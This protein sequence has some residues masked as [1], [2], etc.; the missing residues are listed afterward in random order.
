MS[1]LAAIVSSASAGATHHALR[2]GTMLSAMRT[3][4]DEIIE[5]HETSAAGVLLAMATGTHA[6]ERD[7][8]GSATSI[9]ARGPLACASDARLY[10]RDDLRRAL[11][12]STFPLSTDAELILA[13]YEKWD[14]DGFTRLEGDFAFVLWDEARGRLVAARDFAGH[15]MLYHAHAGDALL[16][17]TTVA[18]LLA[19]PRVPRELDLTAI[20]TVAA[21]LW[22]HAPRTA[23]RAIEELPAGHALIWSRDSAM[24]TVPFWRAPDSILHRRA[25]IAAAA[26]E[27]RALLV[28][29]VRERLAPAGPTGLSLSGGW[30]STAVGGAATVA[31]RGS[32]SRRLLPVSISYPEGD[33]GREDELIR[34]VVAHWGMGTNWLQVDSIP[35]LADAEASARAR[36]LPFGHAYEQWNRALS[37]C[38]RAGGA[39]VML[40]GVGGDQLFQV[41]DIYLS[42]LFG[43][44]RWVELARQLRQ[45]D[46][47]GLRDLWRWAVR[48]ALPPVVQ[49]LLARARGAAPPTHHLHREPPFWFTAR[50]LRTHDLV[51]RD[52]AAMPQL[53]SGSRVLAETH[54]FLRFP[55]FARIVGTLRQFALEEG[56]ELRSPLL[57]DRVMRFAAR[58]PWSERADGR[59]TKILLR[60]A[61]S[62]LLP[63]HVLAPRPHRTGIT[64]A[65]FLRQLR[66][67]ARAFIESVLQDPLLASVG[68]ID[69]PRLRHAWKHVLEHDDDEIGARLYF[70]VQAELWLRSRAAGLPAVN[71]AIA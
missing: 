49:A 17:A 23:Y 58:R 20:A 2:A 46:G 67:P 54:A 9:A 65:Y 3:L 61:M 43:Q 14:V 38:A 32:A 59:E 66:G 60:R 71:G 21:G 40:D 11:G 18:G 55:F 68:M 69:A 36:D 52:E 48:P 53:P 15:R 41:S 28:D 25:P 47:A 26:E 39:R 7:L 34:D 57:D 27:L 1:A 42:D 22:A 8:G 70:T 30:D 5:A 16:L 33:P 56:V 64:S 24:R 44:G 10:H 4:G 29:A 63:D 45:K 37:R 12:A 50:F 35:L 62:G 51:G 13:A 6:W 31:L 19:D